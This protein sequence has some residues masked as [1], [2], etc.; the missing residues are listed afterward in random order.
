MQQEP[1]RIEHWFKVM[2]SAF[3]PM[4]AAFVLPR[5]AMIP[6]FVVTGSVVAT[7]LVMLVIEER[8]GS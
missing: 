2:L 3:L 7:G 5:A 6:M 8:R 1:P 4:G